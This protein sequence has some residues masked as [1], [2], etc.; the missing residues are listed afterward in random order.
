MSAC[1]TSSNNG[2]SDVQQSTTVFDESSVSLTPGEPDDEGLS[3]NDTGSLESI[4]T[5]PVLQALEQRNSA[6]REEFTGK[7]IDEDLL[8][9]L[10]WAATG[11]NRDGTG[12]VV[13]LA[14][15]SE[16]YVSLYLVQES[17]VRKF[18]W[19]DN[20]FETIMEEDIR[21][22]VAMIDVEGAYAYWIYVID[23]DQVP[24][25]NTNW[26]YHTIGSMSEHQYLVAEEYD[27][28]ARYMAAVNAESVIELLGFDAE[29][30]LPAGVMVM[31]HK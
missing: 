13:P 6:P 29:E 1:T 25:G 31:A 10:G 27:V 9:L 19:E 24:M 12:F 23:L 4:A 15:G 14:M 28:Q 30:K 7:E 17:G 2:T 8:Q 11:K 26:G 16:P 18:L 22:Q 20:S 21:S 5:N 3:A